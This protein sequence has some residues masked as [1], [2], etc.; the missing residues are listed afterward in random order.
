MRRNSRFIRSAWWLLPVLCF[1]AAGCSRTWYRNQA[2]EEVVETLAEKGGYLDNGLADPRLDSRMAYLSDPDQPPMPSDDPASHAFMHEVDGHSGFGGWHSAGSEPSVDARTWFETLPRAEDGTVVLSLGDAIKVARTNSRGYQ[3]SLEDLYL[4]ALDVTFERFRFDHQFAAGN[5]TGADFQGRD[6]TSGPGSSELATTTSGAVR[7]LTATGGELFFGLANSIVWEFAGGDG[8]MLRSTFDFSLIQPL[9]RFGGRARVLERLTQSERTL[10]GNVRQME[11]FR[12][13]FYV[14]IA[15]GRNSGSGPN[16][17]GAVGQAGLGVIAGSPSGRNGAADAGGFLGLLQDQQQIQNQVSNIAALRDSLAQLEAAYEANRTNRLQVDQAR[18]ALLNGQSSLLAARASY[19]S[20]V[21]SFKVELGLPPDLPLEITDPLL[22]RFTLIAP[23]LSQLQ[24]DLAPLLYALKRQRDTPELEQLRK[25]AAQFAALDVRVA[26]RVA[27][28]RDDFRK[29]QPLI[30]ERLAQ[31]DRVRFQVEETQADVDPG[32]YDRPLLEQRLEY[33]AKRLPAIEEE[34]DSNRDE[35]AK[36]R[37]AGDNDAAPD[38]WEKLTKDAT[39][40]SDLLLELSLI[41]AEIRLQGVALIPLDLKPD[42][43]VEIARA[44]RLDWMNARAN[45]VDV[46]RQIEVDANNLESDLDLVISGQARTRG[47]NVAEFHSDGSRLSFG[48]EFDTP[49]TRLAE[50]NQYRETLINYQRARRD[51]MLFED[52][53]TQSVRNTLRIVDLSQI[54]FEVRRAAVQVAIAQ[55]DFSR[56]KLNPPPPPGQKEARSSPT[57]A[58]DLVSALSDLLD[59]QNDF[60]NVWVNYEVLRL[61]LDFELGTMELDNDGLWRDPG[62]IV[63]PTSIAPT[64]DEVDAAIL[65]IPGHV[66]GHWKP[67]VAADSDQPDERSHAE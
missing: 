21:D 6:R 45:L 27:S 30:P 44:R 47:D 38:V 18:Q 2:D 5:V 64:S 7:K 46:W 25:S 4:S 13:G 63:T 42:D 62:P 24:N 55:V 32:I 29:L 15:T 17:R 65:N 19:E 31:L 60:L 9:L 37:I 67:T 8:D 39:K 20:R 22:D 53:V 49:V 14:D 48:L 36:S 57:A 61:L 40:L 3:T 11:Q 10:L 66:R 26:E 16:R 33:L 12:R 58:R 23:E 52:R 56:I 41:Q 34:F 28:A 51:Y 50:R 59:A 43:A 54:N 1:A 35:L